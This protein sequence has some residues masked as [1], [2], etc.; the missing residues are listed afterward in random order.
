MSG[1]AEINKQT[2]LVTGHLLTE[3]DKQYIKKQLKRAL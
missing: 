1:I 2:G 3:K